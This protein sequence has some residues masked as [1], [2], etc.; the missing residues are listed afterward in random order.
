[1]SSLFSFCKE[2]EQSFAN[3]QHQQMTSSMAIGCLAAVT[4]NC[5]SGCRIAVQYVFSALVL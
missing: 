2:N 3:H 1:M 5:L 4:K